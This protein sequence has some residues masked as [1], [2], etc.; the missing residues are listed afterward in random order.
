MKI[1]IAYYSETGKTLMIASAIH[2]VVNSEE[3]EVNLIAIDGISPEELNEYDLV[4]VGSACHH[5]DLHSS[6]KN[7]LYEIP[8]SSS[9]KLAGFATHSTILPDGTARHDDLYRKWAGLCQPT[10]ERIAEEKSIQFL[11]Y[12]HCTGAPS[13]MIE[14]FIHSAIIS[15]EMEWQEY[16]SEIRKHPDAEDLKNAGKFATDILSGVLI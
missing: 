1:L 4:F 3:N 6:V 15:D 13:P 9:I 11:G 5:A 14:T 10:F 8:Q 16:I 7:F 2:D 12:F